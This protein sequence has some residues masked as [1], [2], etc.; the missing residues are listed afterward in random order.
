MKDSPPVTAKRRSASEA[1]CGPPTSVP[2]LTRSP[3]RGPAR[4]TASCPASP[5]WV[6]AIAR[7]SVARLVVT[8]STGSMAAPVSCADVNARS[9][10]TSRTMTASGIRNA[11][12]TIEV[13][14]A[15]T[16]A[17]VLLMPGPLSSPARSHRPL[18]APIHCAR[19]LRRVEHH[20]DAAYGAQVPRPGGRLAELAPQPRHV[21]VDGLVVTVGLVPYLGEQ[22][23]P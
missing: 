4:K 9:R 10:A 1:C 5:A 2:P 8:A 15:Q 18:T 22:F 12:A 13:T 3:D 23:L 16:S 7:A 21:D 19:S 11:I 20:A 14:A 17:S 6:L